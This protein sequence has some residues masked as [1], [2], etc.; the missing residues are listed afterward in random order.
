MTGGAPSV[1]RM[2]STEY[3]TELPT[4]H[5]TTGWEAELDPADTVLRRFVLNLAEQFASVADA[6]GGRATRTAMLAAVD[7]GRPANFYNS[8]VLLQPPLD[9]RGWSDVLDSADDAFAGGSGTVFLW[10]P[11][12]T[13]DL[14]GR[15]WTLTGHP[16]LLVRP[17]GG[18][19]PEAAPLHIRKVDDAAGLDDW[20]RVAVD[21][22]PFPDLQ[23]Y[24]PGR[25]FDER[26]LADRRWRF[27]V[28]YDD[29]LPVAIGTLFV[30]HGVA[31]LALA[32]TMPQARGRGT[33]Y[34]LVRERL[35]AEPHLL[36]AAVASDDSR[37]G[38]ERLG[39]L[40][41]LR[42][43]IWHRPRAL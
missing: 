35:L 18:Q 13:P 20:A 24:R 43:T 39:Y 31:Q 21:G 36:S 22:Y 32:A 9:D 11:W 26:L 27:W 38:L 28:A 33:W 42:F 1:P 5:L 23:P 12:P 6:T 7:T 10:S 34:G 15:G 41:L 30:A 8:A 40:P 4:E 29:G 3:R 19:L 16:P 17:P 37:P 2:T 25:L 14:R